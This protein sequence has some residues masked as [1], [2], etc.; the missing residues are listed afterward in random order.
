[1]QQSAKLTNINLKY[2]GI[3]DHFNV[4]WNLATPKL[5]EHSIRNNESN[6]SPSGALLVNTGEFTGR[7]P[8][9]KFIVDYGEKTDNEI[10]WG[11]VNRPYSPENFEKL[12]FKVTKHIA[13]VPIY[14]QD[15]LVG[16][17]PNH[18]RKIRI[19]SEFAWSALFAC[20]LFIPTS[21]KFVDEPDF[22]VIQTPSFFADPTVNGTFSKAFIIINF[23]KRI[24]LIGCTQ[25]AGE[26]KKSV[27]SVMNRILPDEH[28]LPMHCSANIGMDGDTALFF[29]LS[30]TGKTT[31]SSDPDR[32][33][34]GDDEH[35]WGAD[36][37][38]N[39]EG[40]CYAKT[41][42]LQQNLEPI[43]WKASQEFGSVLENVIFNQETREIDFTNDSLTENTRAA[44]PL[45][46]IAKRI[47]NGRGNHPN[48]IFFLSADA[49]GVLP[50][51]SSLTPDQAA[52]Y[53]LS[54]YTSKLAGTERGLSSEPQATFSACFGAPFLPLNPARYTEMLRNKIKEY[55]SKVWLVNTGWTGGQYGVG[56]RIKL[57]YTRAMISA[58]IKGILDE[59]PSEID[60]VFGLKIP[61]IIPGVPAKLLNPILNWPDHTQYLINANQLICKF[62]QNIIQYRDSFDDKVIN[63]M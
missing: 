49:F 5:V 57:P 4:Y 7:S 51:I 38:F 6:L 24:V 19:I 3:N 33:L 44:Y 13:T 61:N 39:F 60:P 29:G 9:D 58:A 41:I 40:G 28:V 56:S 50:P 30:G 2:L 22:T 20:D 48:H 59:A 27:F 35:G 46:H 18:Q 11:S 23:K 42:N 15:V 8:N 25:Y 17:H 37:V 12:L 55:N 21:D 53:F 43:I 26:I 36:G 52:F 54:G 31:L 47:K 32:F 1:M 16:A 63:Q 34:I 62:K 14:A 45:T 10:F